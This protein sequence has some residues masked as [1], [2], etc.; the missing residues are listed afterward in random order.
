M[1]DEFIQNQ[2]RLKPQEE[3]NEV[4]KNDYT[5][6]FLACWRGEMQGGHPLFKHHFLFFYFSL[7]LHYVRNQYF[8]INLKISGSIYDSFSLV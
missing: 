1:E 6:C 5:P 2:E 4:M 8:K 7:A 3:K